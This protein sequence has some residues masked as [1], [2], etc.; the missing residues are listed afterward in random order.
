[1]LKNL[2]SQFQNYLMHSNPEIVKHTDSTEKVPAEVRLD[3][4]GNAYRSR[5]IEAL[6]AS[7]PILEL[8][9]G[10]DDFEELCLAYIA[11]HPSE[12]RSIRWFGDKM[13]DFLSS[14]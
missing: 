12:Y 3:I 8:Y 4:Y 2:E 1:M 5:L 6:T 13:A 10:T 9:F 11:A 7:Y 14:Q